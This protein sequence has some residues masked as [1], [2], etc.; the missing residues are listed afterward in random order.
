MAQRQKFQAMS[1]MG[2]GRLAAPINFIRSI[3]NAGNWTLLDWFLFSLVSVLCKCHAGDQVLGLG[4]LCSPLAYFM[5]VE[6]VHG[7]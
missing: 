4:L 5:N 7:T 6:C 1:I 3:F 2:D